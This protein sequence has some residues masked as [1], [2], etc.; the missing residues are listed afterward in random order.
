MATRLTNFGRNV[1]WQPELFAQ[2]ESEQ[3]LLDLL[4]QHRGRRIRV[5]GRLH[6]WSEAARCDE[7]SLDLRRIAAITVHHNGDEH[8]VEV[9]AGCRIQDL[10]L[11]L[12]RQGWTLPSVG[13]IMDQSIA[14]ACATGTH[15]SGRHSLS[16]YVQAV[17][18]ATYDADT[19]EA[20]IRTIDEGDDLRAARCAIG[21]LGVVTS[22]RFPIRPQYTIR[23]HLN[24]SAVG[25][26][27]AALAAE[28]EH[29]LQQF[30]FYPW[31]WKYA[32][33]HRHEDPDNKRSG[34]AWLYRLYWFL[35]LDIWMHLQFLFM[36]RVCRGR[37]IRTFFSKVLPKIVVENW[38]VSDTSFRQ[39][40][41]EHSLFRHIEIEIFVSRSQLPA[42][43][44]VVEQFLKHA[45]GDRNALTTVTRQ[46]FE[47]LGLLTELDDFC[48]TYQHHYP[49]C[50]R[51]VLPDDTLISMG[52][53]DDEA[54]YAVSFISYAK[55]SDRAGFFKMADLLSRSTA[56][57][58]NARPHWGKVNPLPPETLVK[59]YPHLP[60]FKEIADRYDPAGRF[61]NEW[62]R[63]VLAA[64]E[65]AAEATPL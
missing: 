17:R 64:V 43:M 62:M 23:E 56:A 47:S 2:P 33:Q 4:D 49:I 15:G 45:G 7:V 6:A 40:T 18:L 22:L 11:E 8:W 38:V 21:C 54:M 3:E 46:H 42:T 27:D 20:V 57:L 9:G 58:F 10:I 61:R 19:G 26:L 63:H 5:I 52:S 13:L 44:N 59:L 55:P 60:R 65:A 31:M 16:H 34:V 50:L 37:G 30:Y 36:L 25:T 29:P 48:G 14:G 24:L 28:E 41:M 35:S 32:A 1:S 12:D 51:K 39:L 53:S